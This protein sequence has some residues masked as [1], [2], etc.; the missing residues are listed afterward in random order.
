M[1]VV[2]MEGGDPLALRQSPRCVQCAGVGGTL[3]PCT[4]PSRILPAADRVNLW[5]APLCCVSVCRLA[6]LLITPARQLHGPHQKP[7]SARHTWRVMLV[8]T[9]QQGQELDFFSSAA[10]SEG[11]GIHLGFRR[12]LPCVLNPAQAALSVGREVLS[13][14]TLEEALLSCN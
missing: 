12:G 4:H 13:A 14:G 5:V 3:L 10:A 9:G 2:C 7:S 11:P 8:R 6:T 1:W